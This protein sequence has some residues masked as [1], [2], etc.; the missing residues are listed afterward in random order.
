MIVACLLAG[1]CEKILE[2][3]SEPVYALAMVGDLLVSGEGNSKAGRVR[4]WSLQRAET[5]LSSAEHGGPIW[6]VA[7][8]LEVAVSASYDGSAKVWPLGASER[9]KSVATLSHPN[10]VFSASVDG[11][12]IERGSN[13]GPSATRSPPKQSPCPLQVV[14]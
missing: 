8:G 7:L 11:E 5:V 9:L 3:C 4:F 13:S 12:A 1:A 2:G 6:S 14:L 10:W